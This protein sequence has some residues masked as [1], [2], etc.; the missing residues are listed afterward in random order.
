V[1]LRRAVH[2][3]ALLPVVALAHE[4]DD[5]HADWYRSLKQP[6]TGIACCSHQG[7]SR[8]CDVVEARMAGSRYEVLHRGRWLP[9][10]AMALLL[11]GDNPTG[12]PVACIV[13]G[14]VVCFVKGAEG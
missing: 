10:P 7:A 3:F 2:I 5:A 8:D 13:N 14:T 1:R 12:R 4:T 11:R 9:V 6:L